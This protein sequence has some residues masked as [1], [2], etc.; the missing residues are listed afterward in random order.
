MFDS[1]EENRVFECSGYAL[2]VVQLL[3]NCK[4]SVRSLTRQGSRTHLS[5]RF[6]VNQASGQYPLCSVRAN[7]AAIGH[8]CTVLD[9]SVIDEIEREM[10]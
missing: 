6:G 4:S 2:L 8:G 1:V 5:V 10:G 7:F 9:S 3:V